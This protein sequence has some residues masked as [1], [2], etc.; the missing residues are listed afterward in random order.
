M[1]NMSSQF[2]MMIWN[3]Y[4]QPLLFLFSSFAGVCVDLIVFQT[5][6][7]LGVD[8]SYS[9]IVS[10]GL[11]IV[12]TYFFLARFTDNKRASRWV[13]VVFFGYYILSVTGF[14]YAIQFVSHV[15]HCR[16]MYCKIPSLPISFVINYFFSFLIIGKK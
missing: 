11:A 6:L 14:S 9:N 3:R 8:P 16:P 7:D 4:H 15:L 2:L 10:S 5:L 13:S 12:I 1:Y